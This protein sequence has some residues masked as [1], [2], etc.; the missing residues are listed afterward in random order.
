MTQIISLPYRLFRK[1]VPLIPVVE[2]GSVYVIDMPNDAEEESRIRTKIKEVLSRAYVSGAYEE[3][4]IAETEFLKRCLSAILATRFSGDATK[5]NISDEQY[6]FVYKT[7]SLF[8]RDELLREFH[9][10]EILKAVEAGE[11]VDET[12]CLRDY[13][14]LE[15]KIS[16]RPKR[17]DEYEYADNQQEDSSIHRDAGEFGQIKGDSF[18]QR[19][20]RQ[21]SREEIFGTPGQGVDVRDSALLDREAI[22]NFEQTQRKQAAEKD[23]IRSRWDKRSDKAMESLLGSSGGPELFGYD[24]KLTNFA[25]QTNSLASNKPMQAPQ[26]KDQFRASLEMYETLSAQNTGSTTQNV[27]RGAIKESPTPSHFDFDEKEVPSA[28]TI[29]PEEQPGDPASTT[30][31]SFE[32]GGSLGQKP[33]FDGFDE[34]GKSHTGQEEDISNAQDLEQPPNFTQSDERAENSG[35]YS[36]RTQIKEVKT[37]QESYAQFQ[38][39]ILKEDSQEASGHQGGIDKTNPGELEDKPLQHSEPPVDEHSRETG[40]AG[41]IEMTQAEETSYR[42]RA[43]NS[44]QPVEDVFFDQFNVKVDN[45]TSEMKGSGAFNPDEELPLDAK[46]VVNDTDK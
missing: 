19:M 12:A 18:I 46:S 38:F 41:T 37:E 2:R 25:A 16:K 9:K 14:E 42:N 40:D 27:Q 26:N 29:E 33:E 1:E 23:L 21:T 3:K 15:E 10:T 8:N 35:S 32:F 17:D 22:R 5:F 11:E 13:P 28:C 30:S 43:E 6:F 34:Y 45:A 36:N 24:T 20:K 7:S 31:G 4:G 44:E 39:D